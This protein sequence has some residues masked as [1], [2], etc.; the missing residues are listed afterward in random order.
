MSAKPAVLARM[1]LIKM[2]RDVFESADA[3]ITSKH[4]PAIA[5]QTG[6]HPTTVRLQYYRWRKESNSPS[7]VRS[8]KG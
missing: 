4:L 6:F 7:A 8:R 1:S 2:I 5:E 3:P